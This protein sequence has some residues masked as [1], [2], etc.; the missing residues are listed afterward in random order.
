[1]R[2]LSVLLVSALVFGWAGSAQAQGARTVGAFAGW[3]EARQVIAREGPTE[4]RSGLMGGLFLDVGTQKPWFDILAEAYLVQRGGAVPIGDFVAEAEADYVTFAVLPKVRASLGLL[5]LYSYAGPLV[6]F[7]VRTRA[8]GELAEV[9]RRAAPQAFGVALGAGIEAR[10]RSGN[11]FRVELRR[12]EGLTNAF[13]DATGKVRH[14]SVAIVLRYG[15]R[16]PN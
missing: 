15:R 13:P 7:H 8:G 4:A 5:Q 1:M 16:P 10:L 14:R 11:S 6:D 2:T 3:V 12:D 9:Y